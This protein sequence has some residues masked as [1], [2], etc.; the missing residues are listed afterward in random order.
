MEATAAVCAS[1][2][3]SA[4]ARY[5]GDE[6]SFPMRIRIFYFIFYAFDNCTLDIDADCAPFNRQSFF[7]N[8]ET[9]VNVKNVYNAFF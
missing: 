7:E 6:Q 3:S 8:T 5:G 9:T 1:S 2:S 4:G